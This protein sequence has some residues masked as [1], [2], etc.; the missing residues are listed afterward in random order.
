LLHTIKILHFQAQLCKNFVAPLAISAIQELA[1]LAECELWPEVVGHPKM[2]KLY[3]ACRD[4][5][6]I[7]FLSDIEVYQFSALYDSFQ[8]REWQRVLQSVENSL[9][10]A[11]GQMFPR[12][13]YS[14]IT[15]IGEEQEVKT[16]LAFHIRVQIPPPGSP[17][18]RVWTCARQMIDT[19]KRP[20]LN[21]NILIPF[22]IYLSFVIA[23]Q[24][25]RLSSSYATS[26]YPFLTGSQL[27]AWWHRAALALN[28]MDGGRERRALLLQF[29]PQV[30]AARRVMQRDKP[31][32]VL[33]TLVGLT[34][35][36]Y[37]CGQAPAFASAFL[38]LKDWILSPDESPLP[39]VCMAYMTSVFYGGIKEKYLDP[40]PHYFLI[41]T[42]HSWM[43]SLHWALPRIIP[44]VD[45][46]VYVPQDHL[47]IRPV[48][49][50]QCLPSSYAASLIATWDDWSQYSDYHQ[51]FDA[52]GFHS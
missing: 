42:H 41:K 28:D 25:S 44:P 13:S 14:T 46:S 15:L 37:V 23:M 12:G 34:M 48:C 51:L 2:Q 10:F 6:Q 20:H 32:S 26:P 52:L 11:V 39:N 4:P 33:L 50:A 30:M 40:V 29:W 3:T 38:A 16:L 17:L 7:F 45:W 9:A 5:F 22:P 1:K 47:A 31:D 43:D 24:D 8:K 27:I 19:W 21:P 18:M 36:D 49:S 35:T